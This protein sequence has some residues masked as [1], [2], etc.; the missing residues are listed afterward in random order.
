MRDLRAIEDSSPCPRADA[1]GAGRGARG[2]GRSEGHLNC[3]LKSFY[4]TSPLCGTAIAGAICDGAT[5]T[6]QA[7]PISMPLLLE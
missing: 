3:Q 4:M 6:R 2:A 5:S 1:R 7:L